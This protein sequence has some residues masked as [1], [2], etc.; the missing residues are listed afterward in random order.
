MR[1]NKKGNFCLK[2]HRRVNKILTKR[3][4][5]FFIK[6]YNE[7]RSKL[8]SEYF[9]LSDLLDIETDNKLFMSL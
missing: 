2:K 8:E 7:K 3:F 6:S 9:H 1:M 4:Y 5:L